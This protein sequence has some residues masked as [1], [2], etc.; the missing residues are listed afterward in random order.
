M[1]RKREHGSSKSLA[2]AGTGNSYNKGNVKA[3]SIYGGRHWC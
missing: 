1:I 2:G 3:G